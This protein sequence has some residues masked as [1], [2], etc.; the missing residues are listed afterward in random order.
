MPTFDTRSV[1]DFWVVGRYIFV[2]VLMLG[3]LP[4]LISI[5]LGLSPQAA[6]QILSDRASRYCARFFRLR[7]RLTPLIRPR[8]S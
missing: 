3:I 4:D 7:G 2:F 8:T 6:S 1:D 5:V